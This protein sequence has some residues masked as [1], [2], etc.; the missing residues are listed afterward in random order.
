[1]RREDRKESWKDVP[2]RSKAEAVK[3]PLGIAGSAG[4]PSPSSVVNMGEA[5]KFK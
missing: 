4:I 2:H 3:N 1:M 5:Q